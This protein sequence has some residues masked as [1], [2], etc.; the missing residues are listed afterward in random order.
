VAAGPAKRK[1]LSGRAIK[2]SQAER[3]ADLYQTCPEAVWALLHYERLPHVIWECACGPGAIVRILR[4]A[5]YEVLSTDL[6]DYRSP[7]Q[8]L[9]GMDFLAQLEAPPIGIEAIITNPPFSKASEFARKAIELVPRSYLLMPFR[10]M[11]SG[12]PRSGKGRDRIFALDAGHLSRV[13]VFK[14]RLPMMHREGW[15]GKKSTSTVAYAWFVFDRYHLGDT[16]VRRIHWSAEMNP[17][18]IQLT[19]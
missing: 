13:L 1:A 14:N 4:A 3:G 16:V 15:S 2:H 9:A 7:D 5:R 19:S 18:R 10:F 12:D 8:D 11:E 6:I 17:K